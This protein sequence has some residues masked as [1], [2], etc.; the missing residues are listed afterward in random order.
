MGQEC[1]KLSRNN[2]LLA[3][4]AKGGMR[5]V[6]G[7]VTMGTDGRRMGQ[8]PITRLGVCEVGY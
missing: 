1:G 6:L 5:D 8:S 7:K 2:V 4:E 3:K